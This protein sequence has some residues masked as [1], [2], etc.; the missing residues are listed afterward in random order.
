MD[1][2]DDAV[3][4]HDAQLAMLMSMGFSAVKAEGALEVCGG[5]VDEALEYLLAGNVTE[6]QDEGVDEGLDEKKPHGGGVSFQFVQDKEEE[7]P[8]VPW[9]NPNGKALPAPANTFPSQG[10][11]DCRK[12]K[13]AHAFPRRS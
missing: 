4:G 2:L 13:T 7:P 10:N 8:Q 5:D 3:A 6:E 9:T 12:V 1:D 11:L